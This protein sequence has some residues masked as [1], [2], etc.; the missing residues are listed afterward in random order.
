MSSSPG[1]MIFLCNSSNFCVTSHCYSKLITLPDVFFFRNRSSMLIWHC[2][3]SYLTVKKSY[4]KTLCF[5][6]LIGVKNSLRFDREGKKLCKV[7]VDSKAFAYLGTYFPYMWDKMKLAVNQD[8]K[9]ICD[10]AVYQFGFAE[11][12]K[13]KRVWEI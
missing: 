1:W 5:N 3:R 9:K 4:F 11:K 6:G 2:R 12:I 10:G 8:S 7:F 13:G